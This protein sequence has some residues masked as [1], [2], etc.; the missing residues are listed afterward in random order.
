MGQIDEHNLANIP[1]IRIFRELPDLIDFSVDGSG[2][3]TRQ[4][5]EIDQITDAIDRANLRGPS[6]IQ[7]IN[8]GLSYS[9][10]CGLSPDYRYSTYAA[11]PNPSSKL[12]LS[13]PADSHYSYP[14][15]SA[16]PIYP[17]DTKSPWT[18]R[19]SQ[20]YRQQ[21]QSALSNQDGAHYNETGQS[22]QFGFGYLPKH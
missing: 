17:I 15:A 18:N 7:P 19:L 12:S 22:R 9:T 16:S 8:T 4:Q 21:R 6:C 13:A 5:A 2:R 20:E 11:P 10:M 14:S 3:I 1:Y